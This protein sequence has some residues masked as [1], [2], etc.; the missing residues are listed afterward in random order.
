[1]PRIVY[2]SQKLATKTSIF[3]QRVRET[4]K[5]HARGCFTH[6]TL[7][8]WVEFSSCHVSCYA[9]CGLL[10]R[11]A[12]QAHSWTAAKNERVIIKINK[13]FPASA[14]WKIASNQD[15]IGLDWFNRTAAM[16]RTKADKVDKWG[17]W[18]GDECEAVKW[19]KRQI[20]REWG[21]CGTHSFKW[22]LHTLNQLNACT[23]DVFN[24][25]RKV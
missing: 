17:T 5:I 24:L 19:M 21:K 18:G 3:D 12:S 23:F 10:S 2:W 13:S 14:L 11:W 6:A 8:L 25:I 15:E 22:P 16:M 7:K 4:A 1:M 20:Y 9:I